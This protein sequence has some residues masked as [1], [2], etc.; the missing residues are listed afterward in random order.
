MLG[1]WITMKQP[2]L[3]GQ[4]CSVWLWKVVGLTRP[5]PAALPSKTGERGSRNGRAGCPGGRPPLGKSFR[6]SR[7]KGGEG[8]EPKSW[9]RRPYPG[10]ATVVPTESRTGQVTPPPPKSRPLGEQGRLAPNPGL[11]GLAL[12]TSAPCCGPNGIKSRQRHTLV[13]DPELGDVLPHQSFLN[14]GLFETSSCW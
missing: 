10:E 12:V 2:C 7:E 9:V 3:R 6:G 8:R 13:S 11:I 5:S 14:G 4:R 1:L